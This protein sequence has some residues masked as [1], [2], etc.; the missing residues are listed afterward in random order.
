MHSTDERVPQH[1]PTRACTHPSPRG[2]APHRIL[3]WLLDRVEDLHGNVMEVEYAAE[4][5]D[6]VN[7]RDPAEQHR[8]YAHRMIDISGNRYPKRVKYGNTVMGDISTAQFEIV[9]DYGEHDLTS[10]TPA[11]APDKQWAVRQD[12]FSSYRGGFDLRTYRLCQR[13]LVFH[14]FSEL[15]QGPTLVSSMDLTYNQ[16][17]SIT[18]LSS[19]TH[20]GYI[21]QQGQPN[22]PIVYSSQALPPLEFTYSLPT[23]KQKT[24]HFDPETLADIDVTT[25]GKRTQWV[26]LDGEGA[27]REGD[28]S[29]FGSP[30][31]RATRQRG[32]GFIRS[33][34]DLGC[35][36][37]IER[38]GRL[39]RVDGRTAASPLHPEPW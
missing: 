9:F 24:L 8:F 28:R 3:S 20:K 16:S 34:D 17:K 26:D 15:G 4:N 5:L 7:S 22:E 30:R 10:P 36:S 2:R 29:P 12:P 23:K 19:A 11:P 31:V 14:H 13:V 21:R 32:L 27:R 1:T 35:Q 39:G 18:L 33:S 25:L 38:N 37:R 6:G